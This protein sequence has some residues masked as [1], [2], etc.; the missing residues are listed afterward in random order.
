MNARDPFVEG[1]RAIL[2][3]RHDLKPAPLA[4]AAGLN[5]STLR[6][7]LAGDIKSISV[8][9]ARAVA[10]VAG[11][12]LSTIIAIGENSRGPEI[13]RLALAIAAAD[14]D[15]RGKVDAFLAVAGTDPS[16]GRPL[17]AP[18]KEAP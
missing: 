15:A 1:L 6:K 13:V 17:P 9:N 14:D 5:D 4:V 8:E 2:A 7:L 3:E 11:Y 10:K 16:A 12:D 18:D